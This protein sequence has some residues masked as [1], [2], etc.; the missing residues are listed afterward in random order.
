M[1][2]GSKMRLVC[3]QVNNEI[4][5]IVEQYFIVQFLEYVDFSA[6]RKLPRSEAVITMEIYRDH[7]E[8]IWK[9]WDHTCDVCGPFKI[10]FCPSLR[11]VKVHNWDH[12]FATPVEDRNILRDVFCNKDP[13]V[14]FI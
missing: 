6:P 4:T 9:L 12:E 1:R 5:N 11:R 10:S 7:F 8:D 2:S 3:R 13:D 14:V